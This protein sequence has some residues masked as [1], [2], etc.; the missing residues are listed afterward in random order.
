MVKLGLLIFNGCSF[1]LFKYILVSVEHA[2]QYLITVCFGLKLLIMKHLK[3]SVWSDWAAPAS[4]GSSENFAS[5]SLTLCRSLPFCK[6]LVHF[7]QHPSKLLLHGLILHQ[8][9]VGCRL[10]PCYAMPSPWAMVAAEHGAGPL[11]WSLGSC[12]AAGGLTD[13]CIAHEGCLP[14]KVVAFSSCKQLLGLCR[15]AVLGTC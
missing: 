12:G 1:S 11:L 7:A 14:R 13:S 6:P 3:G 4:G 15:A 10:S 5:I 2:L 8:K 9:H